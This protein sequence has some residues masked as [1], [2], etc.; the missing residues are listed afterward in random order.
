[1]IDWLNRKTAA[2]EEGEEEN[3]RPTGG[4][5]E[6]LKPAN[7]ATYHRHT[8]ALCLL[9]PEEAQETHAEKEPLIR[10][11]SMLP[12]GEVATSRE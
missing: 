8:R 2:V 7:P 6:T 10:P 3:P 4:S 5:A 11:D 9:T 1:M 12:D